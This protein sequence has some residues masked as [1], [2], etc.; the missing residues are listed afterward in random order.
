[1]CR[2]CVENK[3]TLSRNRNNI[4][5]N[6][7]KELLRHTDISTTLGKYTHINEQDERNAILKLF[8]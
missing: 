7:A 2:V 5:P 1:M 8:E 6:V 3:F 4:S